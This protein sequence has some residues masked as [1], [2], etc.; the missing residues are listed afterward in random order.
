MLW[1]VRLRVH[2]YDTH[3]LVN[4]SCRVVGDFSFGDLP[5]VVEMREN[6]L[7]VACCPMWRRSI[8][9]VEIQVRSHIFSK[10][11]L[12]IRWLVRQG[13]S[14]LKRALHISN[15][16]DY[17]LSKIYI[18]ALFCP[19]CNQYLKINNSVIFFFVTKIIALAAIVTFTSYF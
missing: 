13:L 10:W 15:C 17:Y 9:G 7:G 8:H 11:F 16:L 18:F 1:R 6:N 5:I 14:D 2:G 4:I 3:V 12:T 19:N